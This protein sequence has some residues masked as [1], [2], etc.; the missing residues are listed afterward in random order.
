MVSLLTAAVVLTGTLAPAD[1]LVL[2]RVEVRRV[3]N[4][5]GLS[6]FASPDTIRLAVE[7][8]DYLGYRGLVLVDGD[9]RPVYVVDCQRRDE[10]PR[11]SELGIIADVAPQWGLGHQ[12]AMV[13]L[14]QNAKR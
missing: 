8:C 11:L 13:V 2:E 3:W 1:P 7:C 5:W 10:H 14:W 6:K 4:G 12:K 9:V